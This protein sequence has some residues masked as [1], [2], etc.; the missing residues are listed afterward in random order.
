MVFYLIEHVSHFL[1]LEYLLD[2][3]EN[4]QTNSEDECSSDDVCVLDFYVYLISVFN[5]VQL[6]MK[7]L[8]IDILG[9]CEVRWTGAGK[10]STN[11][12]TFIYSCGS[13]HKNGVGVMMKI[14]Y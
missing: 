9:L 3:R 5:D 12:Y 10:I 14:T 8:D 4:V 11:D 2:A 6:E 1:D 7:R 13:E